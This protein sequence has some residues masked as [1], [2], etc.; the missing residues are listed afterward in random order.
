[1]YLYITKISV[2]TS[3]LTSEVVYQLQ[4]DGPVI[5]KN[6]HEMNFIPNKHELKQVTFIQ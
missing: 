6:K 2:S 5:E 3:F 4:L 1:M